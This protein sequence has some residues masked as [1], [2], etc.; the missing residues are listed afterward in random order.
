MT[1]LNTR[2]ELQVTATVKDRVVKLTW[3]EGRQ[4]VYTEYVYRQPPTEEQILE[5]ARF[6]ASHLC[7]PIAVVIR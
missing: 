5:A 6:A 4:N 7:R 1:T 2:P 3:K